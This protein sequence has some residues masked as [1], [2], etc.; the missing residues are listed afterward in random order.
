MSFWCPSSP[1]TPII[2]LVP[3]PQGSPTSKTRDLM[4]T[5]NLNC[6]FTNV[7]LYVSAAGRSFSKE[8]SE[9]IPKDILLD[10]YTYTFTKKK[11]PQAKK[12]CYCYR[13]SVSIFV[14]LLKSKTVIHTWINPSVVL[15]RELNMILILSNKVMSLR[16]SLEVPQ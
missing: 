11:K 6:L 5:S 13:E 16:N 7:C 1:L 3:L 12:G 2:F 10:L 4:E 9:M 14:N 8:I 15:L